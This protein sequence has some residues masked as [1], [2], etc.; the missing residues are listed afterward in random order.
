MAGVMTAAV[1]APAG[2]AKPVPPPRSRPLNIAAWAGAALT[3]A[4]TAAVVANAVR[5]LAA[6][7]VI[8]LAVAAVAAVLVG[9]P[10]WKGL[11]GS[12]ASA[13]ALSGGRITDARRDAAASRESSWTAL[14]VT[15][16]CLCLVAL[17]FFLTVSDGVVRETFLRWDLMR[18]SFAETGKALWY[19]VLIALVAE[20]L[21]LVLGL[22]LALA[23]LAPGRGGR[24]LRLLAVAYIDLF[25]GL[26]AIVVIYLVGF[27]VPL[28]G[29]PVISDA[30]PVV[31]AIVALTLTYSAYNAELYR[32]A[33][34]SIHPSQES[35]ALSLGLSRAHTLRYVI[36]PQAVRRIVPPLLGAFVALQ[37]DTALVNVVGIIDAF[38]QAK[39][40]SANYYNLSSVTVVCLLFVV[41]TIPQTRF[42]DY[43]LARGGR[44]PS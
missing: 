31:Y 38:A 8:V 6:G 12:A 14:G 4:V 28:A 9:V 37:K 42:V 11:R 19:N 15:G 24:P 20:A 25:R 21:V 40:Y 2:A 5:H 18:T 39:I 30:P 26:P 36:L 16:F 44:K 35:A 33:I 29:I 17:V 1:E 23:R 22:L 32:S 27:G 34:E 41:I 43:L 7:S 13:R 10:A 3:V